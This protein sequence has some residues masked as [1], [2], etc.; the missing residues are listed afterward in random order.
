[1]SR[2]M[3]TA[4]IV[5]GISESAAAAAA[6]R[7]AAW[8]S[9]RTSVPLVVAHASRA[10][11]PVA[12]AR[13]THWVRDAL[14]DCDAVPWR[15][16]LL[17]VEEEPGAALVRLSQDA[18][19]LVLGHGV[20]AGLASGSALAERCERDATCPVVLVPHQDRDEPPA[21]AA[22]VPAPRGTGRHVPA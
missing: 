20:E 12:R 3:S 10:E 5:V 18:A 9:Q 17:V 14:F 16:H 2:A 1:M 19:L 7:W 13:A 21:P 4:P 15:T 8:E 11:E 22:A 6:L